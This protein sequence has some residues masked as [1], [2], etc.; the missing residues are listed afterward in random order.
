MRCCLG[1]KGEGS[2][3]CA[4]L[5]L[6]NACCAVN[7]LKPDNFALCRTPLY[8][9][10]EQLA[11]ESSRQEAQRERDRQQQAAQQQEKDKDRQQAVSE[12]GSDAGGKPLPVVPGSPVRTTVPSSP[13]PVSSPPNGSATPSEAASTPPSSASIPRPMPASPMPGQLLHSSFLRDARIVDLHPASW[14]SVA[15][16]PVYRIPDAPLC[17]RFLTFHSF[18]PMVISMQRAHAALVEEGLHRPV[19]IMPLQV[20]GLK[21]YN[22]QGERWLEALSDPAVGST[23]L[24]GRRGFNPEWQGEGGNGGG[25]GRPPRRQAVPQMDAAWQ[26]HLGELQVTAERL[27]RGYGLRVLGQMG[28]EDVKLRHP[29]YEFFNT[30]S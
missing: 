17:A 25:G 15:W 1:A 21:W 23:Q 14:F 20:V 12:D 3:T 29:D 30:R 11:A 28:A 16:Y 10:I 27:A 24:P 5:F 4:L 26:A 9:H 18:A 7:P 19:A 2:K 13:P 8:E 22:M 6:P